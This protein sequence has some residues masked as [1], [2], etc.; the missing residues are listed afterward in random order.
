MLFPQA[1]R[2]SPKMPSESLITIPNVCQYKTRKWL[3][4]EEWS[5]SVTHNH[6]CNRLTISLAMLYIHTTATANPTHAKTYQEEN[7]LSLLHTERIVLFPSSLLRAWE[8][9]YKV[10]MQ[11][12]SVSW[13]DSHS[14]RL[15]ACRFW[16]YRPR[17]SPQELL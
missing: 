17:Q 16:R 7:Q 15:G 13:L 2:V 5:V 14:G 10:A 4:K 11:R 3:I 1:S 8:R 6:T 12:G 9:G